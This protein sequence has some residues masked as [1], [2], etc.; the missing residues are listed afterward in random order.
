MTTTTTTKPASQK[1]LDLISNLMG[2]KMFDDAATQ[3]FNDEFSD[4]ENN[5]K[6]ASKFIGFMFK[7]PRKDGKGTSRFNPEAGMYAMG[8]ELYRVKISRTGNWYA[9]LAVKPIPGSGRKSISWDYIGKGINLSTAQPLSDAEA[10]KF[11]GYCV[12]CNAQ[13]TVKESIERGMGPVCANKV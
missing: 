10:G 1:Q 5:V 7:L 2:E 3:R 9:E 6:V 4:Y 13:L 11:V 12:R 8:G